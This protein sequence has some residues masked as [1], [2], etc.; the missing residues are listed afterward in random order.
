MLKVGF[1]LALHLKMTPDVLAE[2][3]F[4][5]VKYNNEELAMHLEKKTSQN[6]RIQRK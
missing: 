3:D 6:K 2:M 1:T 5:D 4:A